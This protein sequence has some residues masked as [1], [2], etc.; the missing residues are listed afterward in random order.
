MFVKI[1]PKQV[2][3]AEVGPRFEMKRTFS[4][5]STLRI[6]STLSLNHI[7]YEIRQ[8]TIEQNEAE[9]EWVLAHYSRTAKKRNLLTGRN[10]RSSAAAADN[11]EDQHQKKKPRR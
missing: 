11:E 8:G 9:R 5:T 4:I 6:P 7:A 2:Q 1:P 3:L 10:P